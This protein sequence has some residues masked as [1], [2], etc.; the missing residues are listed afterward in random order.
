M[1]KDIKLLTLSAERPLQPAVQL[2]AEPLSQTVLEPL[3]PP[4]TGT[5]TSINESP[6]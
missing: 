4:L 1:I 2:I 3:Q 6:I 5:E